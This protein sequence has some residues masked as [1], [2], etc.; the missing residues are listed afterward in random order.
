LADHSH[1]G[2]LR[3][4]DEELRQEHYAKL[5]KQYGTYIIA[6]AVILILGVA[7]F[8]GWRA[9]DAKA[10]LANSEAYALASRL[11]AEGKPDEAAAAFSTLAKDAHGGYALLSQFQ[12]AAVRA[13]QNKPEEA[14][15]IYRE[16]ADDSGAPE[17]YR[18]VAVILG[19]YQELDT[20]TPGAL[21]ARID[22]LTADT[23]P[24]RHSAREIT[25]LIAWQ[26]GDRDKARDAFSKLSQDDTAAAAMRGRA[27]E[28]LATL[29]R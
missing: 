14:A 10:R 16:I 22:P 2:L 26:A 15:A 6:A 20:A 19:A 27:G 9:Y 12:E 11:I 28:M 17:M 5:W 23:S 8:Q 1:D 18:D 29:G 13:N 24:W 3:E 7:G 4:I 21:S 25:G